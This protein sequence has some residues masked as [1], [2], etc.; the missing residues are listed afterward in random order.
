ME[1]K[2]SPWSVDRKVYG[3]IIGR[4]EKISYLPASRY[5]FKSI[6]LSEAYADQ[7]LKGEPVIPIEIN[8]DE[9]PKDSQ[10]FKWT[11]QKGPSKKE[12]SLGSFATIE[13]VVD[14]RTPI[15]YIFP[16][17]HRK[18]TDSNSLKNSSDQTP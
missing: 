2:I 18:K 15:S 5:Y 13:V 4:V 11:T 6:F 12:V 10:H 16:F 9:D 7:I 17:L 1:A 14:S 8:P 3:E